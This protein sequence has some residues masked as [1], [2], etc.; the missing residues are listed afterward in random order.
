MLL[1]LLL[2]FTCCC[3]CLYVVVVVVVIVYILLSLLLLFTC[4]CLQV[5]GAL[6]DR[7]KSLSIIVEKILQQRR[8][9]LDNQALGLQARA[10]TISYCRTI[11][12]M[13]IQQCPS[14]PFIQVEPMLISRLDSIHN[15]MNVDTLRPL[16]ELHFL[17]NKQFPEAITQC[18]MLTEVH[19][20]TCVMSTTNHLRLLTNNQTEFII[21]T[22]NS[23]GNTS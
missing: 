13:F 16:K 7:R 4:C 10:E 11:I 6:E 22:K 21:H 19:P 18:G 23:Q 5:I 20:Q 3:Y 2:L 14:T 9:T 8:Q 1:L 15:K 12:D 17:V